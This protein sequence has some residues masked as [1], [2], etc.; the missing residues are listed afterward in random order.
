[1]S[2]VVAWSCRDVCDRMIFLTSWWCVSKLDCVCRCWVNWVWNPTGALWMCLA[3]LMMPWLGC[4]RPAAP[5]C[6]SSRWPNR[7]KNTLIFSKVFWPFLFVVCPDCI[8]YWCC[9]IIRLIHCPQ[10]EEFRSKQSVDPCKDVYFM[11][12]TVVNSCGTVGL[13]H[14]VGNNKDKLSFG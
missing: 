6:S 12:Q 9:W 5:W 10:H 11:S 8:G 3:W 1:M 7:W 4:P 14:A 13:L 2:E